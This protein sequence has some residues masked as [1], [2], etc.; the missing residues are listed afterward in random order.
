MNKNIEQWGRVLLP[1]LV[2]LVLLAGCTTAATSQAVQEPTLPP[3]ATPDPLYTLHCIHQSGNTDLCY[4]SEVL[5]A[6][7]ERLE[8]TVRNFCLNK[9]DTM[10]CSIHVWR[11][12]ASVAQA[13]PLGD[14]EAA[15]RIASF[16][17]IGYAGAECYKTYSNGEVLS[18]S[19][20]C[21]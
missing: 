4:V 2:M 10:M 1:G 16:T 5:A 19:S 11:D 13:V 15:S 7:A 18:S 14:A 17:N 21:P 8:R 20:G 9:M 12:E 6:D 3:T